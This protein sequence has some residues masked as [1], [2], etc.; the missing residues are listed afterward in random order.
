MNDIAPVRPRPIPIDL[1]ACRYGMTID[2]KIVEECTGVSQDD[3]NFH[4]AQMKLR[5]RLEH[6]LEHE[7][8]MPCTICI[9]DGVLRILTHEEASEYHRNRF[10]VCILKMMH[11][12]YKNRQVLTAE[13]DKELRK[14]HNRTLEIQ[15][16]VL[17][18]VIEI[19]PGIKLR[20]HERKTP[21]PTLKRK[22]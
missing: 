9:K 10:D 11:S 17:Q 13:F 1:N 14:T 12:F 5:Y 2:N 20:A 15:G 18:S 6:I 3:P 8:G 19:H 4:L 7:V 22:K 16:K 21:L